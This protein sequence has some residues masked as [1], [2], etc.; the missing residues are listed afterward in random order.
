MHLR[1]VEHGGADA[2]FPACAVEYIH[3]DAT[4][5]TTPKCLIVG[6]V[7]KC[8]RLI[9]QLCVHRHHRRTAR[10]REYLGV[11]PSG[12]RERESHILDFLCHAKMAEIWMDD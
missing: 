7:G 10:E 11:R 4:L 3:I 9:A 2:V 5:T 6:E 8:N 12:A 1:I